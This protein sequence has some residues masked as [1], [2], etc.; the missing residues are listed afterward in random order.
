MMR[1]LLLGLLLCSAGFGAVADW[2]YTEKVDEM[3][4]AT[5]Y[6]ASLAPEKEIDGVAL[7]VEVESQNNKEVYDFHFDLQGGEFD[8]SLG[9]LCS[10]FIKID[11]GEIKE[12]LVE[13]DK[14][15]Q[16]FASVIGASNFA[17]GLASAKIL[18]IELPV[19]GKGMMQFKY[20]PNKLKWL[21]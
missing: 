12:L 17:T 7:T 10:G 8:C 21:M 15:R 16:S 3:R 5:Q 19:Q 18:Y 13:I 11:S 1:K 20:E 4:G 9:K 6:F 2:Q 14:K